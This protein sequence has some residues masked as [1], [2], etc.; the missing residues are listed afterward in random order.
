MAQ[1]NLKKTQTPSIPQIDKIG[2][3]PNL[4]GVLCTIDEQGN[5]KEIGSGDST[6]PLSNTAWVNL[7]LTEND[8]TNR[9]FK[10]WVDAKNWIENNTTFSETNL[11]QILLPAGNVG[12][13]VLTE[14]I[15][16]A[17]TDGTIIENLS[18]NI[19]FDNDFNTALKAYLAGAQINNLDL[20][21]EGK[22]CTLYNCVVNNV[23]AAN[24]T[25]V[26]VANDCHF[27]AGD[28]ENY[29]VFQSKCNYKPILGDI[30]NL[31]S[32]GNYNEINLIDGYEFELNCVD[33]KGN[34][35]TLHVT[36]IS[37]ELDVENSSCGDVSLSADSKITNSAMGAITATGTAIV[38]VKNSTMGDV[39][40]E[41]TASL[42]HENSII[43]TATVASGA[44]LTRISEPF[45]NTISGLT[46]TNV[47]DAIDE[48]KALIDALN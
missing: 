18:S 4:D 46:A 33:I 41:D 47:K 13:I 26:L 1:I 37:G 39:T 27:L 3:Y 40:L 43:G 24:S 12:D 14:G 36:S 23:V 34:F 2:L 35:S 8:T 48:L 17:V 31:S 21:G 11:W 7:N 10:S 38:T 30:N 5:T 28:F 20:G 19:T 25:V 45:D 15:R 22:C 44:T 6:I 29:G 16:L 9:I 32:T 42:I